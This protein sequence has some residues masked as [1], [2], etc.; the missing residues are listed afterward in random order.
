MQPV[1]FS[2]KV[3]R[4]TCEARDIFQSRNVTGYFL[5]QGEKKNIASKVQNFTYK[6]DY[7]PDLYSKLIP[8]L[9]LPP[10]SGTKSL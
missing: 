3:T 8:A 10:N 4:D 7:E 2:K 9:Y 1:T 6:F 5:C